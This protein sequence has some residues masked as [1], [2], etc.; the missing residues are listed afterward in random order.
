MTIANSTRKLIAITLCSMALGFST[1]AVA[2][3]GPVISQAYEV[4]LSDFRAPGTAGGTATFKQCAECEAQTLRVAGDAR[5]QVNGKTVRFEAFRKAVASV[6][7][8]GNTLVVVM[9]HLE[10]DTIVSINVSQ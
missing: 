6:N 1:L 10:S 2:E 3:L 9:H 5:Y 7:D 8:R 4:R